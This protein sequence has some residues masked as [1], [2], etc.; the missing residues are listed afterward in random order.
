MCSVT[1]D[2]YSQLLTIY[3]VVK[4]HFNSS[5]PDDRGVNETRAYA[6]EVV[7]WR[8][9]THLSETDL[10]DYLL[11]EL[12]T[13][14]ASHDEASAPQNDNVANRRDRLSEHSDERSRL[15]PG[16]NGVK[17]VAHSMHGRISR[18][19]TLLDD[20]AEPDGDD[21][22]LQFVGLNA[23]EIAA[24][25]EAKK[26]L[27]QK[28]VQRIVNAIWCGDIVFWDSLTVHARKKAHK[29]NERYA[30]V[31]SLPCGRGMVARYHR[32]IY[33]VVGSANFI[34]ADRHVLCDL[35]VELVTMYSACRARYSYTSLY[36]L[37]AKVIQNSRSVLPPS[38]T[39]VP[40][41]IRGHILCIIPRSLLCGTRGAEP[42]NNHSN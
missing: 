2:C 26:F 15:L 9:L 38:S 13:P 1:T 25:A 4:W 18:E 40:E 12:P 8:F 42:S 36:L 32:I 34:P 29:Y 37:S 11:Y 5:D 30:S 35:L 33:T 31:Y 22:T 3:R 19:D 41:G 23:L 6:C 28:V 16:S 10:I 21:P 7:A 17:S 14:A 20:R 24:V 39:Q 27:S